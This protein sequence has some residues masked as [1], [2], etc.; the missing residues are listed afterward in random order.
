MLENPLVGADFWTA[1]MTAIK[2]LGLGL[3]KMCWPQ[4][5]SADY[6]YNQ[7]PLFRW[8]LVD[9]PDWQ[10]ALALA[11]CLAALAIAVRASRRA[12]PVF[13]LIGL[14]F[15]AL[16]PTANLALLIGTIFAERFLYL[17]AVGVA[18]LAAL[19]LTRLFRDRTATIA[20]ASLLAL[21][22]AVRT[23]LR[24]DDWQDEQSLFTSVA[25]EAPDSAKGQF[26]VASL[27]VTSDPKL[28]DQALPHALRAVEILKP[29][30]DRETEA[31]AYYVA[32]MCQR[33]E[34]D[35]TDDPAARAKWYREAIETLQRVPRID[36]A[37]PERTRPDMFRPDHVPAY[38]EL[39][40][41]YERM[42]QTGNA[43]AVLL[44]G[45]CLESLPEFSEEL[46][47]I[48]AGQGNMP[49]AA[50]SLVEGLMLDPTAPRLSG[51]LVRLYSLAF[52][53]SCAVART[54]TGMSIDKN[55]PLVHGQICDGMRNLVE[56]Y[57]AGGLSAQA[58]AMVRTAS[59]NFQ[60]PGM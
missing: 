8:K 10:A 45:R 57:R 53:G 17:P 56:A 5:L 47:S 3:W 37:D 12:K 14:V 11:V 24:N 28:V 32:G 41:V 27:L 52:P 49:A 29:I 40:R 4:H 36:R 50:R 1:R 20:V 7:I 6:S 2:A 46:S 19:A 58:D 30:P 33:L 18:G 55:C 59:S 60:C 44:H 34:G 21:A 39:G 38:L 51:E 16:A 13:F 9:S 15:V 54:R 23:W 35:A 31:S 26:L 22:L 25:A 42:G 48:Y 43:I